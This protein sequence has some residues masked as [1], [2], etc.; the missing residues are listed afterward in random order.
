MTASI[1]RSLL[2]AGGI[3]LLLYAFALLRSPRLRELRAPA[4]PSAEQVSAEAEGVYYKITGKAG[5]VHVQHVSGHDPTEILTAATAVGPDAQVERIEPAQAASLLATHTAKLPWGLLL[6]VL[7]ISLCL[8]GRVARRRM[9]QAE[10]VWRYLQPTLSVD[11]SAVLK[12]SGLDDQDLARIVQGMKRIGLA[13]L[14]WDERSDRIFDR[15]LS[16]FTLDVPFCF[17]CNAAMNVRVPADLNRLPTCPVCLGIFDRGQLEAQTREIAARLSTGAGVVG[18]RG[19]EAAPHF[20]VWRFA[21][22][23]LCFPPLAIVYALSFTP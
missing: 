23:A 18:A 15:R 16:A 5:D 12:G 6:L 8:A 4:A 2:L 14:C 17:R 7:P 11:A 21:L 10:A 1:H 22:W 13:D 19:S 3:L 9:Q 20:S